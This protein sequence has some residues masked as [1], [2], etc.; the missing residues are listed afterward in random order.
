ML[1]GFQPHNTWASQWSPAVLQGEEEAVRIFLA[2]ASSH[3][4]E[5]CQNRRVDV[6][7]LEADLQ[8]LTLASTQHGNTLRIEDRG[9]ACS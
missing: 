8:P 9:A 1:N 3:I 5:M 2:S 4:H 7:G 6:T